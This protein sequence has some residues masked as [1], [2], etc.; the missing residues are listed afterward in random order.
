M[1]IR[2][3]HQTTRSAGFA[4]VAFFIAYQPIHAGDLQI[5]TDENPPVNFSRDGKI[6]GVASEVVA[7]IQRR[8][9]SHAQIHILPWARGFQTALA[10]ADVGLYPTMRSKEREHLFKWVGPILTVTTGFYAKSDNPLQ[11]KS[12][13]EAKSSSPI[14][15]P[16]LYYSQEYLLS[17]GFTNLEPVD[18]PE[19]MMHMFIAGRRAIIVNDN[20]TLEVLLEKFG[21]KK[22]DV[23]LLYSFLKSNAYIAFSNGTSDEVVQQWQS[24]L[25]DMKRDGTFA[26]LYQ[27]W[28]PGEIPPGINPDLQP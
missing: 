9:G 21:A 23:H 28:L 2:I 5:Y 8:T 10:T 26:K 16:R 4:L 19:I 25:N 13:A 3:S 20:L 27:S 7:E 11:I 6:T 22:Q 24:A 1:T 14:L 15:V 17:Q 12:M 18:N